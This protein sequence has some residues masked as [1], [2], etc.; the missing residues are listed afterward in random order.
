[1]KLQ[2]YKNMS[3]NTDYKQIRS[4][5]NF[6]L[7]KSI[8][9]PAY[10]LQKKL[11]RVPTA[12]LDTL[13][14]NPSD[15]Q[16]FVEYVD[17]G[18][19][20]TRITFHKDPSHS[21][22]QNQRKAETGTPFANLD[23][24][25]EAELQRRYPNYTVIKGIKA[26]FKNKLPNLTRWLMGTDQFYKEFTKKEINLFKKQIA[27]SACNRDDLKCRPKIE[28]PYL[29]GQLNLQDDSQLQT[30]HN[31][32]KNSPMNGQ[33]FIQ[34]GKTV[35][36]VQ[37]IACSSDREVENTGNLRVVQTQSKE[38][39]CYT[40]RADSDKKALEQA[41]FLFFNELKT[42][43]KGIT[44]TTGASGNTVYQLDY[45]ATSL[46]STPWIWGTK[47]AIAPFPEREYVEKERAA[48]QK[49]KESGL[50]TIEDPN[51][52]GSTYQVKFNPI[53]F[54]R[55]FNMFNRYENWLPPFMT[56]MSYS[57]RVSAEGYAELE[58]LV[59]HRINQLN[60]TP[61][62]EQKIQAIKDTL[63]TLKVHQ[64]HH[65]LRPEEE[66]IARDYLCKLLGIPLIY[67]CKS[68]TDRT[69]ITNALSSALQQ[70]IDLKLSIPKNV[71]T[72][73]NDYRFKELFASNWMAGHQ[74]TRYARGGEGTV[75]GETLNNKN[76]GLVVSRGINQ[77]PAIT[78]LMPERYL[79]DFPVS[80]I[81]KTCVAYFFLLIP[82]TLLLYIPL[83]AITCIRHLAWAATLGKYP[84]LIGPG[85]FIL[86]ALPATLL[87]NF[88]SI[89]P[90]K[91]L[92]ENSPQI[93]QRLIIAGGKNGGLKDDK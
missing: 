9:S 70:W 14:P 80:S 28:D 1:M 6:T 36:V 4:T 93:G 88:P 44:K 34:D 12:F 16:P 19:W 25:C 63:K 8:P 38:S 85:H 87:F 22:L 71:C 82:L 17:E 59:E 21:V 42:R 77:N 51:C 49:L 30:D 67:H 46:L 83:F 10:T 11:D 92:N 79:A 53:L 32:A 7:A 29:R 89:F 35:Q 64:D 45:V 61:S 54:S 39:I 41:S 56:G 20:K 66:I 68:S 55:S 90:E 2:I 78:H 84:E 62:A 57:Q 15:P 76:L 60:T 58:A 18:I 40:G 50:L 86:P 75:A 23:A 47:S 5:L 24:L 52:P 48:F 74:I 37:G 65:H 73:I 81:V 13:H 91:V 69:S 31:F 43:G 3:F 26:Y 72:L 27:Y 33:S